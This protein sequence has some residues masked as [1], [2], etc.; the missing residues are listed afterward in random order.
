MD[1]FGKTMTLDDFLDAYFHFVKP[2]FES[3]VE[4]SK[5]F[6][7]IMVPNYGFSV[8]EDTLG[9]KIGRGASEGRNGDQRVG[10]R[11]HREANRVGDQ[12]A[13]IVGG[14]ARATRWNK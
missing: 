9:G 4:P 7:D 1:Q 12:Q 2:G 14:A 13:L 6:A 5:K 11:D 8:D 3:F 10:R